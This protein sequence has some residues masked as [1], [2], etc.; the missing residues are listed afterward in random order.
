MTVTVNREGKISWQL[1]R[2]QAF[3]DAPN[4]RSRLDV[5][6]ISHTQWVHHQNN[7]HRDYA[8]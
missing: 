6:R 8:A 2:L 7:P 1:R 3:E 5:Y 4:V